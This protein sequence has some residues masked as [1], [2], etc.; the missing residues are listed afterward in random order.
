MVYARVEHPSRGRRPPRRRGKKDR[1]LC[2][3][4]ACVLLRLPC[5]YAAVRVCIVVALHVTVYTRSVTYTLVTTPPRRARS[6]NNVDRYV[7]LFIYI[8]YYSC[9]YRSSLKQKKKKTP[10]PERR[11]TW[12]VDR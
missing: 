8:I 9:A 3:C 1:V 10:D 6:Q 11:I 7:V 12:L 5:V 2:A 4:V